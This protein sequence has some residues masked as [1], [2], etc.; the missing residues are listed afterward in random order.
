MSTFSILA[1]PMV[2]ECQF[3]ME[4]FIFYGDDGATDDNEMHD[5]NGASAV[6]HG[7]CF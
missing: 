4:S 1:M 2:S 7:L 5:M 3:R 6:H